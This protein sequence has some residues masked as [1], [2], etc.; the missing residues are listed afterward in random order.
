MPD[1]VGDGLLLRRLKD[2]ADIG[3]LPMGRQVIQRLTVEEDTALGRTVGA[4]GGL[5]LAEKRGLAAAGGAAEDPELALTDR[6]GHIRQR[7]A[8][9]L[10]VGKAKMLQT[11]QF[12]H[13]ESLLSGQD[14][15]AGTGHPAAP[16]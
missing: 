14:S 5:Q 4:Q 12:R 11:Q 9:L 3:G 16:A 1:L 6:E 15:G 7:G 2:E 10:G 8:G 13:G